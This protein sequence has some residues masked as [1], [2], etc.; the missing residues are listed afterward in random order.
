M[1]RTRITRNDR[2]QPTEEFTATNQQ[3]RG[4]RTG[5]EAGHL[6]GSPARLGVPPRILLHAASEETTRRAAQGVS[7]L[8]APSEASSRF[9]TRRR[10]WGAVGRWPVC[11]AD[12]RSAKRAI[13]SKPCGRRWVVG[14]LPQGGRSAGRLSTPER[15][16]TPVLLLLIGEPS[17]AYHR[18]TVGVSRIHDW[19]ITDSREGVS[20]IHEEKSRFP[21]AQDALGGWFLEKFGRPNFSVG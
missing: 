6:P 2:K 21:Q 11:F 13:R 20:Q 3:V 1:R 12:R 10:A 7:P 16:C 14:G 4:R 15:S 18:F 9:S 19:R 5:S 8:A 17:P